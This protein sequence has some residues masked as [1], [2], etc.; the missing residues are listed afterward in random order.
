MRA[1]DDPAF[2]SIRRRALDVRDAAAM[3][4][5]VEGFGELALHRG[6]AGC[7]LRQSGRAV[8]AKNTSSGGKS[9]LPCRQFH[10]SMAKPRPPDQSGWRASA[11]K[12]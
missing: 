12:R 4:A 7:R 2:A 5:F 11:D 1:A 6:G 10:R 8:A 3:A 9:A